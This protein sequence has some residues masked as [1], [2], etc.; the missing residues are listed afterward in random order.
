MA[1]PAPDDA[2][3]LAA[4]AALLGA[5]APTRVVGRGS[6][7]SALPVTDLAVSALGLLGGAV[8]ALDEVAGLPGPRDGR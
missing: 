5:T 7:Q 2:S 3:G 1:T 4:A 6:L 8:A